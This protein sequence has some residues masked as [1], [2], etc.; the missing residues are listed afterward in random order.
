MAEN[1]LNMMRNEGPYARCTDDI[2][3]YEY[4]GRNEGTKVKRKLELFGIQTDT[5][6]INEF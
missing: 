6:S 4:R 1:F 3:Q 2:N 5:D